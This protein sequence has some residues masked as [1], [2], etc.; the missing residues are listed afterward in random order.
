MAEIMATEIKRG[1][2]DIQILETYYNTGC[3][4]TECAL[5]ETANTPASHIFLMRTEI[6]RLTR[7]TVFSLKNVRYDFASD[8]I[9]D[10]SAQELNKLLDLLN[11]YP[12]MRIEPVSYTHLTLT[13]SDLV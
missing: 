4:T 3:E 13:T 8:R 11:K 7:E 6:V 5:V 10:Q 9:L 12:E 1:I 2:K